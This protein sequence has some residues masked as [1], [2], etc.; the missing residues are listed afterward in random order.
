MLGSPSA[1]ELSVPLCRL[2]LPLAFQKALGVSQS[3]GPLYLLVNEVWSY[4]MT[5]ATK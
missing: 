4:K 5:W 3:Q 2:A 1:Y